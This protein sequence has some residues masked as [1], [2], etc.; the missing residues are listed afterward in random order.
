[1]LA[2][3][4]LALGGCARGAG[5]PA[6]V[7]LGHPDPAER[8]AAVACLDREPVPEARPKLLRLA[9][10]DPEPR[11]RQAAA[12][13]LESQTGD[14]LEHLAVEE[15]SR[16]RDVTLAGWILESQREALRTA[17]VSVLRRSGTPKGWALLAGR[18][19][20]ESSPGLRVLCAQGVA[21]G[22]SQGAGAAHQ[23]LLVALRRGLSDPHPGVGQVCARALALSGDDAGAGLLAAALL[24]AGPA[25]RREL[26]G[27]LRVATGEDLGEDIRP[28]TDRYASQGRSSEATT[29]AVVGGEEQQSAPEGAGRKE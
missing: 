25:E 1:M 8:L 9:L 20:C 16:A 24:G 3:L 26:V 10:G 12:L 15:L 2:A 21:E 19:G 5:H 6:S 13:T 29:G 23:T 14:S 17:A 22:V 7:R 11:V 28:W 27:L 4:C 18:L